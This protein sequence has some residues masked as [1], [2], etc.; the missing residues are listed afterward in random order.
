MTTLS[1]ATDAD[2]GPFAPGIAHLVDPAVDAH[3]ERLRALSGLATDDI[4]VLATAARRSV[5]RVA[6]V[7]LNRL[8]LLELHAARMSQR[9]TAATS[10]ARWDQFVGYAATPD[11]WDE[12]A[13]AYP[14]LLPRVR[15]MVEARCSA[16]LALARRLCADRSRLAGLLMGADPGPLV[17]VGSE[18][19]DSHRGGQAV[20]VLRFAAGSVVYKPRSLEVDVALAELLEALQSDAEPGD[21]IRVPP[22]L[23]G[24]GYGWAAHVPHR[25]CADA[26]E[27]TRFYRGI[28]EWLAVMQLVSGNDLHAENVVADGPIPVVV[29]CETLFYPEPPMPAGPMGD[30]FDRAAGMVRRTSVR[31]GLLP[32]RQTRLALQGIDFSAVGA[33][34]GQQPQVPLPTIVG[35]GT[36]EARLVLEP[37]DVATAANHPTPAPHPERHWDHVIAGYHAMAGR[38]ARLD[39]TGDL[40]RR[41]ARFAG[42]ELRVVPRATQAYVELA[43]MLWHPAALHD[44]A[45]AVAKATD[46][47]TRQSANVPGTPATAEAVAAEVA[48]LLLGDVPVF[49]FTPETGRVVGPGRT[50]IGAYGDRIAAALAAWRATDARFEES[51][52]RASLVGAYLN[53]G[54]SP[55]LERMPVEQ[56]DAGDL[57]ARRVRVAEDLVRRLCTAAIHGDDGT[58]TWIGP[59]LTEH[60]WTVRPL[61]LDLYSGQAGL[62]AALAAYLHE[63]RRG[64]VPEVPDV[65]PLLTAATAVLERAES[66]VDYNGVGSYTGIGGGIW[67]WLLL[68]RLTGDGR[69]LRRAAALADAIPGKLAD[70]RLHDVLT[71]PAGAIVPVLA[72]AERSG[73]QGWV[74]IA[75]QAAQHLDR[76]AVVEDGTARW[77]S[78][79]A[80]RGLGGYAHGSS[81]IGWALARLGLATGDER[82]TALADRALAFEESLW[83]P[84]EASWADL[85]DIDAPESLTAWCHGAVGIGLSAW[86]LYRRTGREDLLDVA[87]RGGDAA[88]RVGFGW[89]HTLC[90]GDFGAWELVERMAAAGALTD[91]VD[92]RLVAARIVASVEQQGPTE[93]LSRGAFTPGLLVGLSGMV[94]QLL[95]MGPHCAL[96]SVLI[97]DGN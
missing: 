33:L 22:V 17:D 29:D 60:G 11:F 27:E 16:H 84:A 69:Y 48:D 85:R 90:H 41:L 80:P 51:V 53:Q 57:D 62:I 66:T 31:T 81:G 49:T 9:L 78:P 15:R 7:R 46:L 42:C 19:G 21:R 28:G 5:H 75:A 8:L 40:E 82:W 34:P 79:S 71:G 20:A 3:V 73:D 1:T 18:A 54:R 10:E 35:A 59:V 76:D 97:F 91:Q 88:A 23:R 43:R 12:I 67:M 47:L 65:E 24:D 93:G 6:Q 95:R 72:L 77:P 61:N 44:E 13:A 39:A 50:V 45:A 68:H 2:A 89:S 86:D 26:A 38:I 36:D 94:Y 25:F 96:P 92:R 58:A 70:G 83:Q 4:E 37:A 64:A 63:S 52:I 14:T 87:V 55:A 30:A 32:W 74:D 56:I